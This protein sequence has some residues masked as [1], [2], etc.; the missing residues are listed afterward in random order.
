MEV[1]IEK[2]WIWWNKAAGKVATASGTT[3]LVHREGEAVMED[4]LRVWAAP[5]RVGGVDLLADGEAPQLST[6][7][8]STVGEIQ[9]RFGYSCSAEG[10]CA[11]EAVFCYTAENSHHLEA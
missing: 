3:A 9:V 6:K 11:T 1:L 4:G 5:S 10:E 2:E 7:S 8:R